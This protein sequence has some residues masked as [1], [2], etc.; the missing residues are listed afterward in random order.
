MGGPFEVAPA[1]FALGR[2]QGAARRAVLAYKERG[3]RELAA[4]LGWALADA[5]PA[6]TRP[7]GRWVLV[8]APSRSAAARRRGGQHMVAVARQCAAA[9]ERAGRPALVA[10]A[11]RLDACAR[12]S[13]GLD[14]ADR[15]ANLSG[16]LRP[17]KAALPP[18]GTPVVLL[19]DVITTGATIAACTAALA[20]AG[21][22][23]AS[24]L[25]FT[26]A[27]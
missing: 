2:Y 24:A 4:P 8:P 12:D 14:A 11:L 20:A 10:T 22:P 7:P 19:D 15:A 27:G 9:L 6:V 25:A 26:A 17:V 16:R 5:L 3:R 23:V 21:V 13:V 18:P 1:V